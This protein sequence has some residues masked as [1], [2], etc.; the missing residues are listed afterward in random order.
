MANKKDN[1]MAFTG[2]ECREEIGQVVFGFLFFQKLWREE[3]SWWGMRGA[4]MRGEVDYQR[5]EKK[6]TG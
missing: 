5:N 4:R 2:H 1:Y 6:K 3:G